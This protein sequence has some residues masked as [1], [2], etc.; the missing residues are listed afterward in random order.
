MTNQPGH[1]PPVHWRP[2]LAGPFPRSL[3]HKAARD[4]HETDEAQARRRRIVTGV[5][6]TGATLLGLSLSSEP[7]S[8]RFYILTLGV[9]ATWAGGAVSSGPL[10]LAQRRDQSLDRPLVAPVVT[11]AGAFCVFY[12]AARACRH[13][14]AAD[15]ALARVLRFADRGSTPLVVLITGAN[16]VA[17]ELFFRGALYAAAGT[18]HPVA[19]STAA[20]VLATAPT[21]NPALILASLLM[22]LL[23]G[24]QRRASGGVGASALTHLT[25]SVLMVRYLP[26]LFRRPITA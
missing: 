1:A 26:P 6:I 8:R 20:Y 5:G 16:G 2:R 21:R 3:T 22:G 9:A 25:W 23:F 15:R 18:R 17:E 13:L 14:P 4:H 10:H 19:K 24:W 11:G 12:G 7:G